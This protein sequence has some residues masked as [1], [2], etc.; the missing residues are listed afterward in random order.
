[1]SSFKGIAPVKSECT[2]FADGVETFFFFCGSIKFV[3][4]CILLCVV[5]GY[6]GSV[7][8]SARAVL[9]QETTD[10]ESW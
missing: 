4:V 6:V 7:Y 5:I 2:V 10:I 8:Q 3:L 1:M 9:T